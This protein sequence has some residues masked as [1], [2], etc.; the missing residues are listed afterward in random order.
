VS[1]GNIK[2]SRGLARHHLIMHN[3]FE[4]SLGAQV[5][6]FRASGGCGEDQEPN[7]KSWK[8]G[9][10]RRQISTLEMESPDDVQS[11][12]ISAADRLVTFSRLVHRRCQVTRL[13]R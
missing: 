9:W 3:R 13:D 5:D 10:W 6:L 4:R 8:L 11:C 2:L 12:P 7:W 1:I